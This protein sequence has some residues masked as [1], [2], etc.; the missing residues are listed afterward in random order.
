MPA[1]EDH[2]LHAAGQRCSYCGK[3]ITAEEPARLAGDDT[4]VHDSCHK[5]RR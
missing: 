2:A 4:W 5:P 1:T 3:V